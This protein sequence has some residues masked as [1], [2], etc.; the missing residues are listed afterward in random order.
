MILHKG[1]GNF[2]T[3]FTPCVLIWSPPFILYNARTDLD[4]II[5][6]KSQEREHS[7]LFKVKLFHQSGYYFIGSNFDWFI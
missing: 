3:L 2:C 4:V 1:E 6:Q 7:Y 5:R